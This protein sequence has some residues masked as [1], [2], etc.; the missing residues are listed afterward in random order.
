MPIFAPARFFRLALAVLS[1]LLAGNALAGTAQGRIVV[2]GDS[3]S[4]PGNAFVLLHDVEV[5]PFELI[6]AAPYAIGGLH[7]TNGET[8]VEQL[9]RALDLNGSGP[10]LAVPG[11]H[12]NYAVGAARARTGAPF[13][14][15]AQVDLFL[16]DFAGV[17][18]ADGVYVVFVGGNDLRDAIE[19]LIVDPSG[20]TTSGILDDAVTAVATNIER[21]HAAGAR[22]F[23]VPN[24]P[25]L[26]L[27][28][29]IRAQGVGAQLVA[30]MLSVAYNDMLATRL[31]ALEAQLAGETLHYVDVYALLNQT[32]VA[33]SLF[34]LSEVKAPCITPDTFVEAICDHPDDYLFW[35]GIHPTRAGHAIL[36]RRARTVLLSP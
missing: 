35:D 3:L 10:A 25:N 9:A 22:T 24:A 4:D 7:F 20:E 30:Q 32:V 31:A 8:W 6:P 34:R 16:A 18:P 14:L 28:P 21:L 19:A 27:V 23:L 29:A 36:A 17:V 2:F 5:R 15:S 12:S 13:D 26:A 33:P 11:V 1:L